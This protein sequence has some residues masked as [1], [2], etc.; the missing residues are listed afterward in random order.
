MNCS[1][2]FTDPNTAFSACVRFLEGTSNWPIL[3]A[4]GVAFLAGIMALGLFAI[5]LFTRYGR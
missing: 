2:D 4:Y 5:Y 1:L 3:L